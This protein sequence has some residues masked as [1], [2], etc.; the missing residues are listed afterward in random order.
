[1]LKFFERKF[2]IQKGNEKLEADEA[3]MKMVQNGRAKAE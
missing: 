1:M 2:F 3:D